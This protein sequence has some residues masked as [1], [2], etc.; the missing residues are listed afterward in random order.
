ML[1]NIGEKNCEIY[2]GF[3]W[4]ARWANRD[5]FHNLT[6]LTEHGYIGRTL[7]VVPL[8]NINLLC[9]FSL[10]WWSFCKALHQR[11]MACA[12]ARKGSFNNYVDQVLPR[13]D[14]L[15]PRVDICG[16]LTYYLPFV[17][18]S[19]HGPSTDHLP[20][21]SCPHSYWM[22]ARNRKLSKKFVV[23]IQDKIS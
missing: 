8:K 18:V 11:Q 13:F 17:L 21:S 15:P 19:K 4:V 20:T 6:F 22:N 1:R 14:H 9:F 16:R 2:V 12:F 7:E 10:A 23:S 5:T 3:I